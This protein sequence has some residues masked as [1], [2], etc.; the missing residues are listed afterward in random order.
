MKPGLRKTLTLLLLL[1]AT[2][3]AAQDTNLDSRL[4]PVPPFPELRAAAIADGIPLDG[5]NSIGSNTLSP[6]DSIAAL[7]TLQ[8]KRNRRTQWLVYFQ[9][10]ASS[11]R[12]PSQPAKPV[13]F[14]NSLGDKFQFPRSPVAFRIRTIGPYVDSA[15]FW[16]QPVPKDNDGRASVDGTFLSLGLDKSAAAIYRLNLATQKTHAKFYWWISPKPPSNAQGQRKNQK[17]A[18][19][20]HITPDEKTALATWY[21]TLMS[22]FNA[23]GETPD[24]QGI[25]WKVV[26]LPSIWSIVK[27][28]GV[29][30]WLGIDF[31]D[32]RPLSLPAGW[33]LPVHAPAYVLPL[34]VTLNQK[35][36]LET[37]L[38][39]TDPRPSLR[40]CGGIVG[41]LAQN[42]DDEEN[43]LTLRVISARSGTGKKSKH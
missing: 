22:Y 23:V 43:Y 6:G 14:Y 18:A 1:L 32:V 20:L 35:P 8:Q 33:D 42:P 24:L 12:P 27:H 7:I 16:G 40:A 30:A 19:L 34:S 38:I 37:T 13:V 5:F 41:F 28:G 2:L 21:P 10:I 3:A 36:A 25:M 26:S 4:E 17:I 15:S 29:T 39:V 31:E 11:N 9:V